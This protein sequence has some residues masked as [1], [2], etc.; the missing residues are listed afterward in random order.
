MKK[1]RVKISLQYK[2]EEFKV[3]G[4]EAKIHKEKTEED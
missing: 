1:Q 2:T 3:K 4:L